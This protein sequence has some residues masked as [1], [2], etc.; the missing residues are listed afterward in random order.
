MNKVME[1]ISI[2]IAYSIHLE[3]YKGPFEVDLALESNGLVVGI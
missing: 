1:K 2:P 3:L